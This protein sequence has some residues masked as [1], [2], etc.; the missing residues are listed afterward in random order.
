MLGNAI[1]YRLIRVGL[2]EKVLFE[3]KPKAREEEYVNICDKSIPV[4][5]NIEY[6]SLKS[7]VCLTSL[8]NP[9]ARTEEMIGNFVRS[10]V[11]TVRWKAVG[12]F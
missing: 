9:V 7:V 8:R 5:R 10:L 4:R 12:E 1:L 6:R 3:Q 2:I 11:F